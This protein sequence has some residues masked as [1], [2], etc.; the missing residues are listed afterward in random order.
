MAAVTVIRH[1]NAPVNRVFEVLSDIDR[2]AERIQAIA[3]L[4]KL[5]A[6]PV[7]V[8]TRFR[9]TR[10]LFKKEAT[11]EMEFTRFEPGRSY[12]VEAES[13]GAHYVSTYDFKSSRS[14]TDVTLTFEA[15]PVTFMAKLM[16]MSPLGLLMK[17]MVRKC[18]EK[19]LDDLKAF[20]EGTSATVEQ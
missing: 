6:G 16:T 7:G 11:E 18:F 19:D 4:E 5:T 20:I 13:C 14:G 2:A 8:G 10:V 1:F 17:G 15:R 9:E 3:K 12:T